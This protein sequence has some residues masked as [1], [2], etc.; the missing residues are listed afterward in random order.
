MM[1]AARRGIVPVALRTGTGKNML[2]NLFSWDLAATL[3]TV[4]D[5]SAVPAVRR[6]R[7]RPRAGGTVR[8]AGAARLWAAT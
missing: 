1:A 7:A 6:C 8:A 2:D 4:Q 3:G 5:G